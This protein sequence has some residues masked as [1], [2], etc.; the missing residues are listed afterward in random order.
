MGRIIHLVRKEFIQAFRDPRMFV[1]IFIAPI[2]QLFL[3]GYAVTTDVKNI[4]IAVMDRDRSL[5]SRDLVRAVLNSGYFTFIGEVDTDEEIAEALVNTRADVVLVFPERFADRLDRGE[6]APLQVLLDGS[7]SNS[8]GVAMGYLQ[9]ILVTY[10]RG[11]IDARMD[12]L[13]GLTGSGRRPEPWVTPE[14]R[15]QYNPELK[16][17]WYMVPGVLGMILMVI[18][19]ILTSLA[20]TRER[21]IGTMEQL[22]VTPIKPWEL[23][24]G[25]MI[26]FAI[27]GMVDVTLILVVAAGHFGLPMVGSIGLLYFATLIFLFTTLGM[28]LLI[29][30]LSQTQQQAMFLALMVMMTSILL[31]GLM[32]PIANMP[33][34]AQWI[35]YANPLRYFLVIVRGVILKGNGLFILAPEFFMLFS[36]G[37][38]VFS[39][40]VARFNKTI[41]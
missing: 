29:S 5:A 9:K 19:M 6:A 27:I 10:G 13:S 28:G 15:Y 31:S 8:S 26:P 4:T 1:I 16:S 7:E 25:K 41:D 38:I 32:F 11:E 37:A 33:E 30:T 22:V 36:L 24:A 17:S 12:R 21:E 35:T 23:V 20:I 3:F 34:P 2:F 18:T 40:A 39:L 14:I